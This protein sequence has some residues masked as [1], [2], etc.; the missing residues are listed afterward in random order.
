MVWEFPTY[1]KAIECHDSKSYQE[2][3]ALA[4][5]TTE[6]YMQVVEGFNIE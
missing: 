3:W 6:R 1:E 2:G 5:G 4:K